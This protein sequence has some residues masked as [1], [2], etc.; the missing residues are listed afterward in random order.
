MLITDGILQ[1]RVSQPFLARGTLTC[2]NV[3]KIRQAAN[4]INYFL[5]DFKFLLLSL[6]VCYIQEYIFDTKIT[7]H[8][9]K[10]RKKSLL[11]RK[12]KFY[13]IGD[14][15]MK[16]VMFLYNF[17][18]EGSRMM[19]GNVITTFSVRV[20]LE[21]DSLSSCQNIKYISQNL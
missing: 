2:K 14:R 17:C 1:N 12:K 21:K 8:N 9:S 18:I 5:F 6:S 7:V 3:C 20:K 13:R 11:V 19:I 10:K 15:M 16:I 4:I